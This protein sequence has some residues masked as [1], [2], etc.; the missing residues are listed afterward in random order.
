[1]RKWLLTIWGCKENQYWRK[2]KE[3]DFFT[4]SWRKPWN[5]FF[6]SSRSFS[7]SF[8]LH[9]CCS[10]TAFLDNSLRGK[11]STIIK[12]FYRQVERKSSGGGGTGCRRREE[13]KI[14]WK[15]EKEDEREKGIKKNITDINSVPV[16]LPYILPQLLLGCHGQ[17]F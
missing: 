8:L 10:K 17:L 15:E 5:F 11:A 12:H 16:A 6:W 14:K 9:S 1:M 13:M 7:I 3:I 2:K 4:W